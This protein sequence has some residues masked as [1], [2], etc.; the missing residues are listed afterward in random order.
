M[1]S[2]Q[3]D[4]ASVRMFYDYDRTCWSV[5]Y[6][7]VQERAH[8]PTRVLWFIL[9]P[10]STSHAGVLHH[11]ISTALAKLGTQLAVSPTF[12]GDG[13]HFLTSGKS[14]AFEERLYA[15][16]GAYRILRGHLMLVIYG[17][18]VRSYDAPA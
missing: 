2:T 12:Q 4:P 14:L 10:S 16:Y 3:H 5:R 17:Y 6:H 18:L 1:L 8:S 9:F 7:H 13:R 15:E 11:Q